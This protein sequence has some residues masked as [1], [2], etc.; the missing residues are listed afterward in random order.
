MIWGLID[1]WLN[2][3]GFASVNDQKNVHKLA[4]FGYLI[5]ARVPSIVADRAGSGRP[6]GHGD[7]V[8]IHDC[9]LLS[10]RK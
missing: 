10:F 2:R 3:H 1:C 7:L 6:A 9:L 4:A 8:A 5:S